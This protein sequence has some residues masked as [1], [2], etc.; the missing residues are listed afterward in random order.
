MHSTKYCDIRLVEKETSTL[1]LRCI[2][3]N[4][5]LSPIIFRIT[6]YQKSLFRF[7][8]SVCAI[9]GV[10]FTVGFVRALL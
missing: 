5:D 2:F 4:Y 8:T 3:I 6:E 1:Q 10:V 7:A 9:I